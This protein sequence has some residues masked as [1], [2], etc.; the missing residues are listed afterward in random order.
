MDKPVLE[1]G[2]GKWA[3][4]ESKLLGYTNIGTNYIPEP[5]DFI[6]A[7]SGTLT[8][9][10]GL[11]E[12]SCYNYLSWT[13]DFTNAAW[14]K[15]NMSAAATATGP[16][17]TVNGAS[18]LTATAG[19][20]TVLQAITSAS[21]RRVTSTW[22]KR[23][24]GSGN[25][26]ITQDNGGTWQ[27]MTVTSGWTQ[28]EITPATLTDPTVGIR[29]VTNGDAVDVW[30]FQ[31]EVTQSSGGV[32]TTA[33]P[34]TTTTVTRGD[35]FVYATLASFP[36]SQTEDTT[37][38]DLST[39]S[40]IDNSPEFVF[41]QD[42]NNFWKAFIDFGQWAVRLNGFDFA[43]FTP[44]AVANQRMQTSFAVKSGDADSSKNGAAI[45]SGVGTLSATTAAF[46]F[47]RD[48]FDSGTSYSS[49]RI[50]RF[51]VVPRQV[52]TTTG[53]LATWRYNF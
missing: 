25:I 5:F 43:S 40:V 48:E 31:N 53:D 16:E 9:S 22:I 28:V 52:Q 38:I 36:Y 39:P 17:G 33:I 34:T 30:A 32:A 11:I 20:A 10:Q 45:S 50:Y 51:I 3:L 46:R 29:I 47:G 8:N 2:N 15:S 24:T 19:N 42:T 37:Y 1:L 27:T 35:D 12:D 26:D 13:E 21:A 6:R 7:T 49:Y 4:N 44:A 23:R 41:Y 14:T 18:T